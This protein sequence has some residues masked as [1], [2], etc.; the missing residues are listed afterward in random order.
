[1]P[2]AALGVGDARPRRV[3][4]A[5]GRLDPV[6]ALPPGLE[7]L[8]EAQGDV[9]LALAPASRIRGKLQG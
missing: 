1:L 7:G 9:G 2:E 6:P 3:E 4:P 5:R 8:V